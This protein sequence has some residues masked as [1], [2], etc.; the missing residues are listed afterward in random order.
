M[1]PLAFALLL[2]L[3]GCRIDV[4][5]PVTT[6]SYSL[7]GNEVPAGQLE[8]VT[9]TSGD[10]T[11]L[12][13]IWA[14]QAAPAAAPTALY[15]HGQGEQIDDSWERIQVIWKAGYN[16]LAIDYHGFGKSGG[17]PSEWGVYADADAA[18]TFA[19]ADARI[20]AARIVIW[21]FSL[22]TGV[23]SELAATRGAAALVLE[24]PYTSMWDLVEWS[25][26]YGVPGRWLTDAELDTLGR[27]DAIGEPLVVAYGTEDRRIPNWMSRDVFDRAVEPKRL[28]DVIGATHGEVGPQGIDRIVAGLREMA[29][30]AAP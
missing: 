29:P 5:L 16:V 9:I 28:V 13:A 25:S 2:L 22:G 11:S 8:E 6:E 23:A 26:P 21:G 10:G 18:L 30:G 20:D 24:A 12:G 7:P 19:A 14:F 3:A 15:F 4:F 1:R 17:E 27:I